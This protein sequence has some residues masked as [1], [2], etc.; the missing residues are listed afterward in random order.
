[1]T[2]ASPARVGE[3]TFSAALLDPARPCP[4]GLVTWNGSDPTAR[5]AVY[6]NNVVASLID[7]RATTFP[8]VHQLVG[9][10]FFR[11]MAAVFVRQAPPSSPVLTR[12]GEGF[13]AFVGHFGPAADLPYLADVACLEFA[14]VR[15]YH[16]ADATAV[17]TEAIGRVLACRE[18][19]GDLTFV[20]HPSVS[21]VHSR[22]A[23]VSIWNAHQESEVPDDLDPDRAESALILRVDSSVVVLEAQG[24]A[25]FIDALQRG[26]SPSD[27]AGGAAAIE[28]SFDL[29]A[30]LGFLIAHGAISALH[31][32]RSDSA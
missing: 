25:D 6:R 16:A 10:D 26:S 4:A 24:A 20:L 28:P 31:L 9:T 21:L 29:S 22:H 11:A 5:L 12:Y 17:T 23:I 19:I 15:A 7:A 1:M 2:P 18:A 27:A 30:A 3:A 13:A 8:V 14:R 32:P